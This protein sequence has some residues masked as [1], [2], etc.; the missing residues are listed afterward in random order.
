MVKTIVGTMLSPIVLQ[1]Q[2]NGSI[3]AKTKINIY[4]IANNHIAPKAIQYL[5][6]FIFIGLMPT[7]NNTEIINGVRDR[8]KWFLLSKKFL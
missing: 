4:T 5:L 3:N 2:K 7:I 8:A 1:R 6:E